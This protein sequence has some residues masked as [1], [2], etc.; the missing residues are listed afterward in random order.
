MKLEAALW[1]HKHLLSIYL[2]SEWLLC[3]NKSLIVRS[4]G[5]PVFSR[6]AHYSL[7][8]NTMW[9]ILKK[10]SVFTFF[11][12]AAQWSLGQHTPQ[13]SP[14]PSNNPK[15]YARDLGHDSNHATTRAGCTNWC[16]DGPLRITPDVAEACEGEPV[17]INIRID[18]RMETKGNGD[19][20]VGSVDWD[21]GNDTPI[22]A[23]DFKLNQ[24]FTHT[25]VQARDYLPSA[26]YQA[27]FKYHGD[28]SC[29][30]HCE[31]RQ[32]ARAVIHLKTSPECK[33]GRLQL[34]PK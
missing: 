21:D 15:C 23:Y 32:A 33:S 1:F 8:G 34:L 9:R 5:H 28:G 10:A 20:A 16:S 13:Y 25:Y 6:E 14:C 31:L 4:P 18:G 24:N 22:G 27:E 19:W 11:L 2:E 17:T 3:R 30:Y 12:M 26:M 29:S 7:E